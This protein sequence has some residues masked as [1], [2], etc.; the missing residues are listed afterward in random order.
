MSETYGRM[1]QLIEHGGAWDDYWSETVAV[2][3]DVEKLKAEHR[4]VDW[5]EVRGGWRTF[6]PESDEMYAPTSA[7]IRTV[8]V[9][10]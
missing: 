8:M 7:T 10:Q 3:E 2:S 1:W 4:G 5:Q 6:L 9:V